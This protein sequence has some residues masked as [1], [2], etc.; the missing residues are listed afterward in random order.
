MS[1][2]LFV[3]LGLFCSTLLWA[4]EPVKLQT[5]FDPELVQWVTQPGDAQVSGT[6]L[7]KLPD[8]SKKSCAGFNVEL[9]PVA[10]YANERIRLTYGNNQ[11]GQ[12]LLEQNPP[13][14]TPDVPEYHQLLLKSQCDAQGV[15]EFKQVPQGEYYVMVFIIWDQDL[16]AV[17]QAPGA[18]IKTG[19]AV[20]KRIRVK[21]GA[22]L[23]VAIGG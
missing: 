9:L 6:A 15:F 7:I 5:S 4:S 21:Q 8:G 12:I 2:L 3:L 11:Q 19:G 17:D 14:F 13:K 16:A 18:V 1:G 23:N 22:Q 20:M 10:P